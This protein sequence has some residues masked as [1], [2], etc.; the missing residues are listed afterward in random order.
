MIEFIT[1]QKE[2]ITDF[3]KERNELLKKVESDWVFFVDSDEV[4]SPVLRQEIN[5]AVSNST[6]GYYVTRRDFLFGKELKHGEF[7]RAGWFGNAKILRLGRKN[8]GKWKRSVHEYWDIKGKVGTLKNPLFH[9]PHPDLRSF[10]KNINYFST[11]HANEL[12]KEGKKSSPAK[13]VI[14]PV[15]K[16]VY[17]FIFRLGFLDGMVGFVVA[18]MMSFHSFLSWSKEWQLQKYE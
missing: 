15:G 13:I 18:L 16:F 4:I 6:N 8:A 5:Q 2:G 11:L 3:A 17:N 14:W 9:Y 10:I 1:L 7:S 12:L